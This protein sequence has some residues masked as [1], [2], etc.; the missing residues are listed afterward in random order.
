MSMQAKPNATDLDPASMRLL[1]R[2][3]ARAP[4]W[5]EPVSR[6]VAVL[7][8]GVLGALLLLAYLT[9]CE[10]GQLCMF[11]GIA[12]YSARRQMRVLRRSA[13]RLL[14]C[15]G[16]TLISP[17]HRTYLRLRINAAQQDVAGME[18]SMH[19]AE[20][21]LEFLP[22]QIRKTRTQIDAWQLQITSSE[23]DSRLR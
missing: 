6:G 8:L 21:E 15:A 17:L 19:L 12:P 1:A 13:G 20:F 4:T 7:I 14:R 2:L 11:A 23:L 10:A 16:H 9:P 18:T 5:L 3:A 22:E